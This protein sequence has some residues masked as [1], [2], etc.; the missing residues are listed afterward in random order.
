MDARAVLAGLHL[1]LL[2]PSLSGPAQKA[3]RLAIGVSWDAFSRWKYTGALRG[4]SSHP[5]PDVSENRREY[6]A[7]VTWERRRWLA[8]SIRADSCYVS[9][10]YYMLGGSSARPDAAR[11]SLRA[12]GRWC[13]GSSSTSRRAVERVTV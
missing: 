12:D 8:A 6:V 7:L 1:Y 5:S 9:E 10:C 4:L 2:P 3:G 13:K 11:S